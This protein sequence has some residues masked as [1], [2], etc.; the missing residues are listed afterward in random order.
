MSMGPLSQPTD[1]AVIDAHP[2]PNPRSGTS[3]RRW[4]T[5]A[6]VVGILAV[7]GIGAALIAGRGSGS[8]SSGAAGVGTPA[9]G[10]LG[11]L[12]PVSQTRVRALLGDRAAQA[13]VR[14]AQDVLRR[15]GTSATTAIA[16]V[17]PSTAQANAAVQ[18]CASSLGTAQT[19]VFT[20]YGTYRA[21]PVAVVAVQNHGRTLAFVTSLENCQQIL[22]SVSH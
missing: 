13:Q 9:H 14:K 15:N 19:V 7:L 3:A 5:I 22:L 11:A 4:T 8:K 16:G 21:R 1:E 6:A 20:G 17:I 10:A 2:E 12:G 18:R